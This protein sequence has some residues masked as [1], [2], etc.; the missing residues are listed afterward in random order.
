MTGL[1]L[2]SY[3]VLIRVLRPLVNFLGLIN[4]ISFIKNLKIIVYV[5]IYFFL[6]FDE[7][8]KMQKEPDFSWRPNIGVSGWVLALLTSLK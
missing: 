8:L 3:I 6:G 4:K 7:L 1:T 2:T 5:F